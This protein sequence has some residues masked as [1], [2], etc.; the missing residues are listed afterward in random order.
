MSNLVPSIVSLDK[1]L[2]LQTAKLVAPPGSVLDTLNYEQVD[3]QGQKRIDGF[4]RYDGQ[5]TPAVDDY[6][7]IETTH[8]FT[9]TSTNLYVN[10]NL[11]GV[12]VDGSGTTMY[13]VVIDANFIPVAGDTLSYY[14]E[15]VEV[16][17]TV[18]SAVAGKDSGIT[19]DEH[20]NNLLTFTGYLRERIGELPGGVAGLHWF[21]DRLYAVAEVTTVSLQGTTPAIYPNDVLTTDVDT[22]KVLD[23]LTLA[24]TRVLFLATTDNGDWDNALSVGRQVY[25]DS[26]LMG[27][28][29]NG[30][31]T[32]TSNQEVASFFESRSESQS[33]EEDG[34]TSPQMVGWRFV[35]QGWLVLFENGISLYG[36]LPSLNQNITGLGVQGPTS[37]AGINGKPLTLLQKLAVAG[38]PTQVNGWK[39]FS[40]PTTY[41]L[42]SGDVADDDSNYTYAD[43]FISWD[44][45]TGLVSAPGLT[46]STLTEYSATSSIIV[47]LD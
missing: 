9:G 25:R 17:D 6:Y 44:G 32:I 29:A 23:V 38:K 39:S 5:V 34:V 10:G 26:A 1:G 16:T 19:V 7:K 43:A 33:L 3:F 20:Y 11:F 14:N 35:D 42:N 36:S 40:T 21:R 31:E 22:S 41:E 12:W 18:V 30:Y 47:D 28:I 2:N 13:A 37:I 27:T 15:L 4:A 8:S 24:N 46:T 45:T